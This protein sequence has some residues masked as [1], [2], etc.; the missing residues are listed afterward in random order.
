MRAR[1]APQGHVSADCR[2]MKFSELWPLNREI[3]LGPYIAELVQADR[4]GAARPFTVV[5]FVSSVDGR[6]TVDG[7]SGGLGDDGDKALFRALREGV[8]VVL[9]GTGTLRAERYGRMLRDPTA[10]ERRQ[11][12]GI[13]PEPLACTVTRSGTL[14][15]DI[16]LFAEPDARVI[17]FS[18]AEIDTGGVLAQVEVVRIAPDGAMFANALRHL[19][20]MHGAQTLLCEGG[21][22]VFAQ[23]ARE[24]VADQLFLTLSPTLVGGG[25]APGITS[26]PALPVPVRLRL[27]GVL[28]RHGTLFLRYGLT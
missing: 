9:A 10:R 20:A 7:R 8:D 21:P 23:L 15:L 14:P 19:Y 1:D 12:R 6:A 5:N 4:P 16:P 2:A 18:G 28:E 22:R 26:G 3:E 27:E 17:V 11:A 25:G 13:S 24:A